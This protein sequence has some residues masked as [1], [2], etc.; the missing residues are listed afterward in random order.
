M[1]D[2]ATSTPNGQQPA[3]SFGAADEQASHEVAP[4]SQA[5][6]QAQ[7]PQTAQTYAPGLLPTSQIKLLHIWAII[8]LLALILAVSVAGLVMQALPTSPRTGANFVPNQSFPGGEE[9]DI[10][11]LQSRE[12]PPQT[13]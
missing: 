2:H 11:S 10:E 12:A 5:L 6:S 7:V 8:V 1:N 13:G 9:Q 4:L 3:G